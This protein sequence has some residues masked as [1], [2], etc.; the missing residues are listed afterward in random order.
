MKTTARRLP[1]S[2]TW[3]ALP[4]V[5]GLALAT[6]FAGD[7][8]PIP[9]TPRKP[10]VDVYHGVKVVDDYQWLEDW[11]DPAVR[12]WS[13]AESAHA[14]AF[15]TA[16][17]GRQ[18]IRDR[19][20]S[21][22][23]NAS[24][25]YYSLGY[26]SGTVFAMKTQPPKQQPFLVALKPDLDPKSERVVADPTIVDPSGKTAI[27]FYAPS[28]DGRFVALTLS[29][30]G[31]EN[32][33]LYI[34]DVSTGKALADAIPRVNKGTAG[35]GAAWNAD[36]TG[37]YYTRYPAPGE[38]PAADL[39]FFQQIYF[40][41]LGT[42][43]DADTYSLGKDFPRIAECA[44]QTSRDGRYVLATVSNGDG[45]QYEHFLL[46]PDGQWKQI[47]QFSDRITQAILAR[48]SAL[49]M[50]SR[51]D[52][53][54]G[55]ILRLPLDHPV[56]ADARTVVPPAEDVI[57]QVAVG[58][59][60]IYVEGNW[61]GPS[62]IRVFD[63]DGHDRGKIPI[64]N[65]SAVY[66][67]LALD[68]DDLLYENESFLDPPAWFRYDPASGKSARTPLSETSPVNFSDVEV[69]RE[70]AIS[71]D[72]TKVPMTILRR[73]G[74][75][76]EGQNPTQ[77]TAYG[78]YGVNI[79]PYYDV[80]AR[81]WFDHGGVLVI[82][83][84]RGGAEYGD[85]WHQG[86]MLTHKQNV[87]DDFTACAEYLIKSGYTNRSKLGIQG[88]SNGGLLMG[89]ALTQHPELYRAVVSGVGIYDMLRN[90][91]SPN[92]VF[93]TTEF[94]SVNDPEQFN[95]LY[96]YSP[97]HHVTDGTAYPAVL[98]FTGANDPRVN[99][100][101]SR[102]MT[103]RLQAATSSGLPILLR[104]SYGSGHIQGS[105]DDEIELNADIFAF[106]FDEL[107]MTAQ[108]PPNR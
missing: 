93:N 23:A 82:A 47:T 17:P 24:A 22:F 72:G 104:A 36:S 49:Y 54:R 45:G 84:L 29:E 10:V 26:R 91:L 40:H 19:L 86:G 53:A 7:L 2:R 50:I 12:A 55:S 66:G 95:A 18:Q 6:A 71:K 61:G 67:I 37:V 79:A 81:V 65:V 20:K 80:T 33:T 8:P 30:G 69:L 89:A 25:S 43:A 108:P 106:L 14:R 68:G 32:G 75:R 100:M 97:Y 44:L 77:L 16:L 52:S 9:P 28:P 105:L 98:F 35:G 27:D 38:R 1:G 87:F 107:H 83:N 101:N 51:R 85:D 99:P 63:L 78:G 92:A 90:E 3:I 15:L 56:L 46:G 4:L 102:K 73:K 94:G 70:F 64:E 34:Y 41:K 76:L 60:R 13:D 5:L 88:A 62:D 39:D 58:A 21:L 57:D 48:D 11:N 103:A 59:H 96:A 31:S 42:A 74:T